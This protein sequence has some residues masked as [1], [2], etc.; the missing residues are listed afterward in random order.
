M[1]NSVTMRAALVGAGTA[2]LALAPMAARAATCDQFKAAITEAAAMYH[3]PVP[4]F[5]VWE[6]PRGVQYLGV[7]IF[8]DARSRMSCW[9]GE[10]GSFIAD[11]TG[12]E[13]MAVMHANLLAGIGL[14][15]FG[16]AW[17][18]ALGTREQLVE[19]AKASGTAEVQ[20]EGGKASLVI[21]VAGTPSFEIETD[22][23]DVPSAAH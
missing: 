10:V 2:L 4:K 16:L 17:P 14:H 19:S 11:T 8:D 6:S 1:A 7:V 15:A 12:T 3:A 13:P 20:F 5:E 22:N 23:P 18:Q 21:T 9:H